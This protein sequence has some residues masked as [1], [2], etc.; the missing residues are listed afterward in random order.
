ML[1]IASGRTWQRP[2]RAAISS[3]TILRL[4]MVAEIEHEQCVAAEQRAEA[5]ESRLAEAN[6][7]ISEL[8]AMLDADRTDK[9]HPVQMSSISM[10][11]TNVS[12]QI[13]QVDLAP[14]RPVDADPAIV[15]NVTLPAEIISHEAREVCS[16]SSE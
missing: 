7:R 12:S 3:V 15:L 5:T 13:Q 10:P 9:A 11:E 14:Y 16:L 2:R 8:S 6:R 1:L 4:Q